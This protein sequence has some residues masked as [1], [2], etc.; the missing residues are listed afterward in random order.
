V[1]SP[2]SLLQQFEQ[3]SLFDRFLDQPDFFCKKMF[4]GLA[5]YYRGLMVACLMEGDYDDVTWK[6]KRYSF[7]LWRGI[8]IPTDFTYQET[9]MAD[10]K[11]TKPHPVLGKWL[12]LPLESDDYEETAKRYIALLTKGD[13][14]IGIVPGLRRKKTSKKKQTSKKKLAPNKNNGK[15]RVQKAKHK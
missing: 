2:L 5:C 8:L 14:R 11:G 15:K 10:L 9:L 1:Q 6:K 13:V 12:Y 4:G 7:P 3:G